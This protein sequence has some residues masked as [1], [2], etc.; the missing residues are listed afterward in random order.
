MES[1]LGSRAVSIAETAVATGKQVERG[2]PF[3]WLRAMRPTVLA[4][5]SGIILWE[6]AGRLLDFTFLP[7][8]S[9]VIAAMWRM[10]LS[11]E[12]TSNLGASL[13]ALAVGY[14]L[15]VVVGVPLGILMGRYR[16]LEYVLDPYINA[17]LA[18]PSLLYVPI[19]FGIF[20]ISRMTQIA[21]I[22][23]YALIIITIVCMGGVRSV[24]QSYTE[25]AAAF[26]AR[27]RQMF[28]RV[29]LPGALPMIM[30][31]LRLGMGRA[32][33]GMINGEMVIV[34]VGMGAL[35]RMYGG[36]FDA[37]SVYGLLLVVIII[38]LICTGTIQWVE[39]RVTHWTN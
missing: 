3:V 33:R 29:L 24:D 38:A 35:M 31:G 37:A 5:A 27:D 34:L 39:R 36:R 21:V 10:I 32:V 17:L 26:G 12:I 13:F 28:R 19:M 18:T 23:L 9:E 4:L 30:A 14:T 8:F 2:S 15:A 25:M 16:T 7:P 6:V 1:T 22:F 11:G 20:G